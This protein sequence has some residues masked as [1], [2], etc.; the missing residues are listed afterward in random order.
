[1]IQAACDE[2]KIENLVTSVSQVIFSR[3]E[4][5]N[6]EA[7][8]LRYVTNFFST[9]SSHNFP[10]KLWGLSPRKT[11]ETTQTLIQVKNAFKIN[12][13]ITSSV[14]VFCKKKHFINGTTEVMPTTKYYTGNPINLS[15]TYMYIN[16]YKLII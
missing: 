12:L 6:L 10:K 4:K 9:R 5:K 11:V 8:E 1:M 2:L 15:I 13:K 14:S 3:E 16:K 7:K